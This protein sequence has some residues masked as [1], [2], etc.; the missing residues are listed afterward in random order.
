MIKVTNEYLNM[1]GNNSLLQ[2]LAKKSFTA[3]TSYWLAKTFDRLQKEGAIFFAER[4]KLIE[5]HAKR[6]ETDGE[7]G[8]RKW[9]KGDM[10]SDGKSVSLNDV[11]GFSKDM[12]ELAEIEIDLGLHKISFDLDREPACTVEE[13]S[14]LVPLIEVKE[15][16]K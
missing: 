2:D 14:L 10:I 7:E 16:E 4:Q 13:M 11:E 12:K 6:Y 15:G 3:K 9:K 5:K 8:E 1:I